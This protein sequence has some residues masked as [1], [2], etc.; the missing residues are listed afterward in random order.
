MS[1]PA[2]QQDEARQLMPA[3]V[4]PPRMEPWLAV[5]ASSLVP[6]ISIIFVPQPL[7]IPFAIAAAVLCAAG[8][9]ILMVTRWRQRGG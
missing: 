2:I 4:E 3:H 1:N 6:A 7:Q 5:M 8:A 9:C